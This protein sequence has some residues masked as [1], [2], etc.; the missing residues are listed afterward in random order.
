MDAKETNKLIHKIRAKYEA[1]EEVQTNRCLKGN[2]IQLSWK[3][4]G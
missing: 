4:S 2:H 3:M 1:F